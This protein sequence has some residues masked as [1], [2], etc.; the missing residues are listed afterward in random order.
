MVVQKLTHGQ[1]CVLQSDFEWFG[2]SLPHSTLI[3]IMKY[4][5]FR[6]DLVQFM[7]SFLSMSMRFQE[8]EVM[9]LL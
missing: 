3:T 2:P 6:S 7:Q 8:D 4:F 9:A 1:L 5:H